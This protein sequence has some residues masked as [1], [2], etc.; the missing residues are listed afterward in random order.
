VTRTVSG[1]RLRRRAR[2]PTSAVLRVVAVLVAG[3]GL[4]ASCGVSEEARPKPL[5]KESV[6]FDLLAPAVTTTSTSTTVRTQPSVEVDV[7]L[8]GA[9]RLQPARRQVTAPVNAR[10]AIEVLFTRRVSDD[11][12]AAGL[13]SAINPDVELISV[14]ISSTPRPR[15]S[16]S[17]WPRSC[18]PR[19][20]SRG[21]AACGSPSRASP[22]RCR[23]TRARSPALSIAA[24]SPSS[25]RCPLPSRQHCLRRRTARVDE[26]NLV[27]ESDDLVRK[28]RGVPQS[29]DL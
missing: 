26:P 28:R 25:R 27:T 19:P 29:D 15:S 11:E 5:D 10:K 8:M 13:R 4:V 2:R 7:F 23:R 12:L 20:A 17:H 14:R 24:P 16:E 3:V 9:E 6:P 22:A 21:S 18:S 1:D